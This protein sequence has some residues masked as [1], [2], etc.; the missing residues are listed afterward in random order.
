MRYVAASNYTAPRLAEALDVSE[1][2]GLARYVALQP[3]YNLMERGEYESGL[4]DLRVERE[5]ACVPYFAL[6]RAS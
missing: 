4:R 2:D 6:P 3:E 5:L 1:R